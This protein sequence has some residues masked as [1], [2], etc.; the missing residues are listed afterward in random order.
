MIYKHIYETIHPTVATALDELADLYLEQRKYEAAQ[1]LLIKAYLFRTQA[2]GQ[3]HPETILT[4]LSSA[5]SM[6]PWAS[7]RQPQPSTSGRFPIVCL[8]LVRR[9]L[10]HGLSL[11]A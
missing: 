3:D 1:Q 10:S 9:I 5:M 8:C 4:L 2:L 6:R 11:T 7:G